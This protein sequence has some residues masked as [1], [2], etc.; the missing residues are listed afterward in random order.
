[1]IRSSIESTMMVSVGYDARLAILEIEFRS[2]DIYEYRDV[3]ELVYR[4]LLKAP[5][6]GRFFHTRIDSKFTF[7]QINVARDSADDD[8]DGIPGWPQ[9]K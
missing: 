7:I 8:A 4:G 9:I 5:S 6:K 3:P 2:G 1:M